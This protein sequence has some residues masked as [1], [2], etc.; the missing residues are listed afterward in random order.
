MFVH[1]ILSDFQAKLFDV[2]TSLWGHRVARTSVNRAM[3]RPSKSWNRAI[4]ATPRFFV[5]TQIKNDMNH[6]YK[7]YFTF[8]LYLFAFSINANRCNITIITDILSHNVCKNDSISIK[9][10]ASTDTTISIS[11][12][13]QKSTDNITFEDTDIKDSIYTISEVKETSY[14]RCIVNTT[15]SSDIDTS[16]IFTINVYPDLIAGTIA[17]K[18]RICYNTIPDAITQT[19][20]PT[21]SDGNY[22]YQWQVASKSNGN[23]TDIPG[24]TATSYQPAAL[25]EDTY[26]RLK[27]TSLC[28]TVFSNIDTVEVMRQLVINTAPTNT[29]CYNTGTT[30]SITATGADDGYTFQWITWNGSAWVSITAANSAAYDTG[31][32]TDTT[33]F[34][35]IVTPVNGCAVDTS[36]TITV[37]VFDDLKISQTSA[38]DTTICFNTATT[39]TISANGEGEVFSYQWIKWVNGIWSDIPS[40]T[41]ATYTTDNLTDTTLFR[42]VAS[43]VNGCARDTSDIFTINVYPDLTA[44]T[45]ASKQ[46][47]CYNT[48]PDAITQTTAP[49]GSDGDYTYQWQVASK[50]N[51]NWTD[52]PGETATSY[53]PAALAEDTYFRLKTTSLCGTV[54]SNIDTVEVMR[55]LV[56]NTAPTNTI[57]YNTNATISITATGA[58]DGYTFQWITWNGSAWVSI[59]AANS[60]A[61]DTGNLTDTTLFRCIVT[62]VNGCAVDTSETITVN[63][64]DEFHQATIFAND[65]EV[66]YGF[67]A[68]T[69]SIETPAQGGTEQ[70]T[71][72]WQQSTDNKQ[73]WVDI[74]NATSQTYTP[75]SLK[76]TTDYRIVTTDLCAS[77]VSNEIRIIVNPLPAIQPIN[78]LDSVGYNQYEIFSI[79][80]LYTGFSYNW[81][82]DESCA[83]FVSSETSNVKHIEIYWKKPTNTAV[84]LLVTNDITGCEQISAHPITVCDIMAPDRTTVIRKSQSNILIAEEQDTSLYFQWGFT[85]D[86]GIDQIIKNS[87]CR[88]IQLPH[89]FNESYKYWLILRPSE[90]TPRYVYSLSHYDKLNDTIINNYDDIYVQSV[91]QKSIQIIIPNSNMENVSYQLFSINGQLIQTGEM[92][93]AQIIDKQINVNIPQGIYILKIHSKEIQNSF[94]IIIQ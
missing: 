88:Y 27:T 36:E 2:Y 60:A 56:I 67:D 4:S 48:I 87:N 43:P 13:W 34:R 28:G 62:P 69:L 14:L 73:T 46:R 17:S 32:L 91:A 8:L 61:Y 26:F 22:T 29:I 92:G 79:D 20:A 53:Q 85:D 3:R 42:C 12:R 31:N 10:K 89:S 80:T 78:G 64:F 7:L 52:I 54:F 50:S 82:I 35:C 44:G 1:I 9:I 93:N 11:Y 65:Q 51:G 33:L 77:G 47:I 57:C 6:K 16:D 72:Q 15:D 37:N 76:Q 86:K 81:I 39:L 24:E 84:K 49:T 40:A 25:A 71:Y 30:L 5:Y 66:C 18:Q 55:Q 23:W 21:G 59:T 68:E 45:I 38:N 58:D 41:D 19:T 63:V 94:K 83:E 75:T 74:I 90:T 70:Y